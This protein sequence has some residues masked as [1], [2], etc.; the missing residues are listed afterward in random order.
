VTGGVIGEKM[1]VMTLHEWHDDVVEK[2][3]WEGHEDNRKIVLKE[4][5]EGVLVINK[6]DVIALAFE[7]NLVVY[8]KGSNL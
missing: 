5:N 1:E 7:F 3:L 4:P 2:V 6:R 8:K